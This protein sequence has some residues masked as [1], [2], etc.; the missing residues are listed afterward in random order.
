MKY[1]IINNKYLELIKNISKYFDQSNQYVHNARNKLKT[2]IYDRDT[3]VI[4]S[5]K[6]PHIIN[7]IAYTFFRDSKAKKSYENSLKII[8][9]VPNPIGYIEFKKFGLFHNSYFICEHFN[10]DFTIRELLF[11]DNF[12]DKKIIL[13]E[14]AYFTNELHKSGIY[15][16]DYS[17]GNILIKYI[18]NKYVFKLVDVNR[19]EFINL[20]ID[21]KA[22]NFS[23]IWFNDKDLTFVIKEYTNL[24]DISYDYFLQM[25]IKY[26]H[27][28]KEKVELKKKLK[29][30]NK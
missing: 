10:Y 6:I 27:K 28:H 11:D 14:F 1:N 12:K 24:N 3:L 22:K 15:H 4:K 7:K 18:D 30:K 16:L 8:N 26:S 19:M 20:D 2:I 5:F 25:A 13:K 9:F 23:K 17:P 21:T 29:G